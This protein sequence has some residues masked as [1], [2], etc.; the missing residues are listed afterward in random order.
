[1][2]SLILDVRDH[3][4]GN[5]YDYV[6]EHGLRASKYGAHLFHTKYERVWDYVQNFSQ[7]MPFDHRVKGL[8]PDKDNVKRLVPIPPTQETVNTLFGT[9]I[10]SEEEM[11]SWYDQ[12][13]QMPPNGAEPANGE[14][15]ALS[16]VG[17]QLY[18]RI[19]KHCARLPRAPRRGRLRSHSPREVHR[20]S[21]ACVSLACPSLTDT[22][23]QWDKY[24]AELDASV[25]M[26]LPC[27]TSTDD[28]YFGDQYQALPVRGYTRIFENMCAP[29][30][31]ESMPCPI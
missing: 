26:R 9:Q 4:G 7:W 28:R 13:R 30:S 16:R 29:L 18:D 10:K 27:R 1:M 14:E 8:V 11:S 25:L 22:K 2:K 23:K 12:N 21:F 15:A 3:I 5:C 24:T 31:I 17:P 20:L 6:E 19:F